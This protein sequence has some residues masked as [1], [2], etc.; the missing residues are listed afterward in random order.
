[1]VRGEDDDELRVVRA[2]ELAGV[3]Q[4]RVDVVKEIL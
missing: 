4:C 1:V 2:H 3:G